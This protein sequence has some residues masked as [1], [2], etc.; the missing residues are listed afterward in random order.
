MI[1]LREV[2]IPEENMILRYAVSAV[3]AIALT[4]CAS[5]KEAVSS[6]DDPFFAM[7][8]APEAPVDADSSADFPPIGGVE[9]F[10]LSVTLERAD[11]GRHTGPTITAYAGQTANLAMVN[12]V[13]YLAESGAADGAAGSTTRTAED[14]L[15]LEVA[16]RRAADGG[17]TVG[18]SLRLARV[19][20]VPDPRS[21]DGVVVRPR[22][23]DIDRVEVSGVRWL[24]P[25]VQG[26]LARIP[27]PDGS[28]P[29]LVL[30]RVVPT[31]IDPPP[32]GVAVENF[33][34]TRLARPMSGHTV[35]LRVSAAQVLR[36]LEP[37]T[38][39]DETAAPDVLKAA[40]GRVLR[41]FEIFSCIDSRVHIAGVLET[42]GGTRGLV[43][44]GRDDGKLDLAW[45]TS[46]GT[47]RAT[48]RPNAG[49]RFVA[50]ARIEGGGTAGVIVSVNAD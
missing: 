11:L 48:M 37:G 30:A 9:A 33:G 1:G 34:D 29:M 21:A 43:A 13:P 24:E 14:G 47:R 44:D 15:R 19:E 32:P 45:T 28:G 23:P 35:H 27:S 3:A 12:E 22:M 39:L 4:A 40:D 36:D 16:M 49:R 7:P 46:A 17:V 8:F 10:T 25:G 42:H 6:R 2:S 5:G 20:R 26:L 18:Y 38:V 50:L 31:L 41:D